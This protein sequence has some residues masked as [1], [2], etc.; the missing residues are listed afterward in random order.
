MTNDNVSEADVNKALGIEGMTPSQIRMFA[1]QICADFNRK[2]RTHEEFM[3]G[4][5][6]TVT[7]ALKQFAAE[8]EPSFASLYVA[9]LDGIWKKTPKITKIVKTMN[10]A[11][12]E[13]WRDEK[14]EYARNQIS[15]RIKDCMALG[16]IKITDEG[17]PLIINDMTLDAYAKLSDRLIIDHLQKQGLPLSKILRAAINQIPG[18]WDDWYQHLHRPD[19]ADAQI[20]DFKP[21]EP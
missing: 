17:V 2:I 7:E 1:R 13:Y 6:T 10:V 9:L 16:Q 5:P 21:P 3:G 4:L 8:Y 19:D 12:E 14:S 15:D 11:W 18:S 20:V